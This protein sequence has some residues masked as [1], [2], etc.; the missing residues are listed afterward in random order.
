[1]IIR[2]TPTIA[3][4]GPIILNFLLKKKKVQPTIVSIGVIIT[5]F[6][7]IISALTTNKNNTPC[8]IFIIFV[9]GQ[10][11]YYVDFSKTSIILIICFIFI[12]FVTLVFNEIIEINFC[13]LSDNTRQNITKRAEEESLSLNRNYSES[14]IDE[15]EEPRG[16]LIDS[17]LKESL[18]DSL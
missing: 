5:Q 18:V 12:L 14:T 11:G 3:P 2:L 1:M 9:F 16:S 7:I 4:A 8:H 6:G 17:E 10:L 13:G 15:N